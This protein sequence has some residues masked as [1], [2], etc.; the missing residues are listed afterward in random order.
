MFEKRRAAKAAKAQLDEELTR[1]VEEPP[2]GER[3]AQRKRHASAQEAL[4]LSTVCACGH[5][6][7][8]HTGLRMEVH[9]RCLECD[10]EEFRRA[11]EMRESHEEMLERIRAALARVER[12]QEKYLQARA[13][14]ESAALDFA[15][16]RHA[17]SIR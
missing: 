5:T 15:D 16:K 8:D 2:V 14:P 3:F 6:R 17:G 13:S 7:N 1:P 10:C 12:L 4:T 11:S 9:G